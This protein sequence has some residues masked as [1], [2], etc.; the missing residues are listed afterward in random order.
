M[1]LAKV[2]V[3]DGKLFYYL[4]DYLGTPLIMT[5]STGVVVWEASHDPFG[6]TDIFPSSTQVNNFRFPGQ[7]FD[8]ETGLHYNWFRNYNPQVGRYMSPDPIG[9]EGGINLYS[10]VQNNPINFIDLLGL[11]ITQVWRPLAGGGYGLG[12]HTGISVNGEIYGFTADGGVVRED[13][14]TY[15]WGSHEREVYGGNEFDQVMLDYLRS[16]AMGNDPKFTEDT[17][18]LLTNN[19]IV[20]AKH[21]I[22]EVL[23]NPVSPQ[24]NKNEMEIGGVLGATLSDNYA[25][26]PDW[27]PV[28][29]YLPGNP[30]E[31]PAGSS[32][33]IQILGEAPPF[34]WTV[35][36]NGFSL[37]TNETSGLSNILYVEDISCGSAQIQ[38][39]TQLGKQLPDMCGQALGIGCLKVIIVGWEDL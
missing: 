36:G 32:V 8:D 3:N 38:I 10:Y 34:T 14:G 16:A 19:C 21:A 29:E 35:S 17:Y 39:P 9:L 1:Y 25:Y 22:Q 20:F 37:A 11:R 24:N 15:N 7:Y 4:N 30:D 2:S 12:Y 6:T 28:L 5:D 26:P 33:E 27:F 31:V 13:P 18:G 23:N